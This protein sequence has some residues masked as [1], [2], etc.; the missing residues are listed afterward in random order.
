MFIS[1]YYDHAHIITPDDDA[2][3]LFGYYD[4]RAYSGGRHLTIRV[5]EMHTLPAAEDVA[6]IGYVKDGIF[7]RFAT[8]TAWNYQQTTMLQWHPLLE[9]TV[10]YNEFV[11]GNCVTTTHNITTGE[12]KRTDR[13]TACVSPDGKWGLSVNFGRIFD[14]RPG[15][16]YAGC[17]DA[18]ADINQP[19][20]DGVFLVNMETGTSKML[21]DYPTLGKVGGFDK[22]DKILVNHITFNPNSTHYCML[23]RNFGNPAWRTSLMLGD[24]E[25]NV[26]TVLKKTFVSH[27]VWLDDDHLIAYCAAE[28][29]GEDWVWAP[30]NTNMYC[31]NMTDGTFVKWD[32]PYFHEQGNGDIHCNVT[33]GCDYVIGDG[34]PKNGYRYL[35]AYNM[36]T[37][38]SRE[39]LRC[40]SSMPKNNDTRCDLH[41]RFIDDGKYISFDTTMN[42]KRQIAVIPTSALNF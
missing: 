27:Y 41:A 40:K 30:S 5:P 26:R 37:G 42:D 3:Y 13:P 1:D 9:D 34:Y 16:G 22:D 38:A 25:G 35:M 7:T 17:I 21:A 12:K 19:A 31:I 24:L 28:D 18:Y 8:T 15:Y 32:M 29:S 6:E 4:M 2:H 23:V 14:F 10:Y 11:N 36:K 39:L 20:E 33:P